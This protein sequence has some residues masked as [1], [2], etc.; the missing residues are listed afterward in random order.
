MLVWVD[1][2]NYAMK[3]HTV[4]EASQNVNHSQ[5]FILGDNLL[6]ISILKGKPT[7]SFFQT[8]E[9]TCK[10]CLRQR[11]ADVPAVPVKGKYVYSKKLKQ[12]FPK[13]TKTERCSEKYKVLLLCEF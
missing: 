1:R 9:L 3:Q 7:Q 6:S 10:H 13:L 2:H 5:G 8:Q 12:H 4:T 11:S